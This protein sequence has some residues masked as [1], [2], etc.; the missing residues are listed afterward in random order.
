MKNYETP[1]LEVVVFESA[2]VLMTSGDTI[3][4]EPIVGNNYNDVYDTLS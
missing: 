4:E 1:E 2:D 3:P